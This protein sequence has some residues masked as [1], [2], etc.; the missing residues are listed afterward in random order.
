MIAPEACAQYDREEDASI[1]LKYF[2]IKRQKNLLRS[3]LSRFHFSLGVGYGSTAFRHG[4]EGF[5]IVQEPDSLPKLVTTNTV[6]PV[7][8]NWVNKVEPSSWSVSPGAFQASSDTTELGFRA[9]GF[10]IPLKATLHME[11]DRYRVGGGYSIE[12]MRTGSFQPLY[13]GSDISGFTPAEP[14]TIMKKYFASIGGSVYRYKDYLLVLSA[15][16]GGYSLGKKYDKASLSKGIFINLGATVEREISEHFRLFVR[17]SYD[18]K[19]YKIN[20]PE[21]GN[22]ITHHFNSFYL[23]FGGT[24][25]IPGLPRCFHKKCR[26]QV[27]HAHGNKVYR[28]RVHPFYKK[29]NPHHGE[30]YRELI[31]YK[32][33]NKRKLSPY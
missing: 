28:S 16:F 25:R 12:Y 20:F 33:R 27:D 19:N 17:P 30:N 29:Q 13:Y 21:S 9:R 26:A 15:D 2:Y 18:L 22:S 24:Y 4:L 3:F 7:Y 31:K 10:N 8:S 32:G 1:P 11:F 23:N 6:T 14:S 5:D